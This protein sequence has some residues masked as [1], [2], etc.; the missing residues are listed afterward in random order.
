MAGAFFATFQLFTTSAY[1][2]SCKLVSGQT[3]ATAFAEGCQSPIGL[4]TSGTLDAS[5]GGLKG[6]FVLTV[7]A[8]AAC[9][10][11]TLCYEGAL[12]IQGEEGSITFR[13]AGTIDQSTG[14]FSD[15]AT[16]QSGTGQY[17]S[18]SGQLTFQGSTDGTTYTGTLA[19][20]VCKADSK[21]ERD[22]D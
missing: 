17:A 6:P 4:C 8:I 21:L 5:F 16:F 7:D 1:A 3:T 13:D 15:V 2:K 9:G 14:A 22:V 10:E 12:F 19:G 18:G 20:T 11:T